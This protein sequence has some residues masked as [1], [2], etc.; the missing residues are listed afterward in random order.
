MRKCKPSTARRFSLMSLALAAPCA[1]AQ[2]TGLGTDLQFGNGLDPSGGAA[3]YGC[4]PDGT[5]WLTGSPRRTPTGFLYACPPDWPPFNDGEAWRYRGRL[6][7]GYLGVSGDTE[8]MI[9]RRYSNWDDGVYVGADLRFE[10]PLDGSYFDLRVSRVNEDNQY[11]RAVFGRAGK[12]RV[13]AY[14]RSQPNVTSGNARSIWDGVG[15][16]HLTLKPGLTPAGSTP[17]QAAAVSAAQPEQLLQV[18]RDKQGVGINYFINRRWIAYGN[19]SHETREGARPFGGA[20]YFNAYFPNNGGIYEVPRPIDDSTVNLN[21]GVR[22]VGNLWRMDFSYSGSFFRHAD[23]GFDYEVPFALTSV[24][25]GATS[26]A[27]TQGE[28]SYEPENDYHHLRASFT[29]KVAWNGEFS[30]TA[31]GGTMRQND[32]LLAPINCQG[33]FG[34][35][36]PGFLFDCADWNTTD[37]LSRKRAD[38]SVDTQLVD[39]RVVLQPSD[40]VTWR[41]N[42]KYQRED[43][44][45]TYWAYNPLTGQWGYPAEN[46]SPGSV[47]PGEAGIWVPTLFTFLP[48]RVRNLPLDRELQEVSFGG[49]WSLGT[50]NTLGATYIFNRTERT[51]REVATTRDH[52]VKLTWNNRALDWLTFRANYSWLRRT[53]SEYDYDPYGFTRS[54]SLPGY[55]ARPG[56][57][58]AYTVSDLRKY[59]VGSRVQ[60]KVDLMATFTLPRDMTL[61]ASVRGDWND[62]DAT[63]GRQGYDTLGGSLQWEWQPTPSIVTSAWYGYDRSVLD[64]ANVNDASVGPD[65]EL[66]GNTYPEANRWWIRDEQRNHYAGASFAQRIGRVAL[67]VAW[68][69]TYSRGMTE[70]RFNSA[71]ALFDSSVAPLLTGEFPD[72]VYRVNGF[73]VGLA[74]PIRGSINVRLFDIY[75]RGR[76]FDWHYLGFDGGQVID[77][78]VY[79][80]G[81]PEDYNT[82]M[83]GALLEMRL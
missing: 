4:D 35:P 1:F 26:P 2:D 75:Q 21:G 50:R 13:Q 25:P 63:L 67:D 27:L 49:D 28:F 66:G 24:V 65:P 16:N 76:V 40:R 46:G 82:N 20:F 56:G 81:G 31:S 43:Y 22:F 45:G 32:K 3:W 52:S 34:I 5:S 7:L 72:M 78:R 55:V 59:D 36:L 11:V 80:D 15:S 38:L 41:A 77:H 60:N 23:R 39:A 18:V 58:V 53:G 47:S 73:R 29:R 10:K 17:A 68:D 61:S 12:Y 83:V 71:G 57:D 37:A 69:W 54:S 64:I 51:H 44:N 62:Y 14:A 30:L 48:T 9:W 79:T 70:Y 6:S 8:N 33:Q 74:I 42:A 19:V